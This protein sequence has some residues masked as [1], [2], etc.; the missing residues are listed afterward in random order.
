MELEIGRS[1]LGRNILQ[2]RIHSNN[3][4]PPPINHLEMIKMFLRNNF[5][6]DAT[7]RWAVCYNYVMN[8]N[9]NL[10]Y[11]H[12]YLIHLISLHSTPARPNRLLPPHHDGVFGGV[13]QLRLGGRA[14]ELG[15]RG[16]GVERHCLRD[17]PVRV[18]HGQGGGPSGL[19]GL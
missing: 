13:D 18:H 16:L 9:G 2:R 8:K 4:A 19:P 15:E 11:I 14:R 1:V 10:K 7:N 17:L 12:I 5:L 6:I 3:L